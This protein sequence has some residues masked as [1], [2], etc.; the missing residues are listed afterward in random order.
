MCLNVKG[1]TGKRGLRLSVLPIESTLPRICRFR[2]FFSSF[3]FCAH[4]RGDKGRQRNVSDSASN[5]PCRAGWSKEDSSSS[6]GNAGAIVVAAIRVLKVAV[7]E[8]G[9]SDP[10]QLLQILPALSPRLSFK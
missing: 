3:F 1:W 6:L 4:A 9:A 5:D 8:C 10:L 2:S 7:A